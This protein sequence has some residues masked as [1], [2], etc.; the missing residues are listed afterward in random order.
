[1]THYTE[2]YSKLTGEA[3]AIKARADIRAY[4][5]PKKYVMMVEYAAYCSRDHVEG[6]FGMFLGVSGYP[7]KAFC[8]KFCIHH[9]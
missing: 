9:D 6:L 4:V 5:G 2:D 3:K 8:D 7:V 1:M